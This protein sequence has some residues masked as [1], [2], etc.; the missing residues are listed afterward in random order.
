LDATNNQLTTNERTTKQRISHPTYFC[1]N[2][3]SAKII[4]AFNLASTLKRFDACPGYYSSMRATATLL[5]LR[6]CLVAAFHS[7]KAG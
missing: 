4:F 7:G 3:L 5:A 1:T 2:K 6:A